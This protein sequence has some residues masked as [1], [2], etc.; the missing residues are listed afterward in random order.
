MKIKTIL[1][2]LL[3]T[4]LAG[5][6]QGYF[7][8]G[9]EYATYTMGSMKSFQ[10]YMITSSGVTLKPVVN[11]P[12]FFGFG[13]TGG[14]Q[15]G[16]IGFGASLGYNTTAGRSDYED[17]SGKA[18]IDQLL[19]AYSFH[20]FL[21]G[22]VNQS[23]TWPLFFVMDIS[24]I[25]TRLQINSDVEVGYQSQSSSSDFYS[26]NLGF[27]PSFILQ[28]D[29]KN[30]FFLMFKAGYEFQIEGKLHEKG[31]SNAYLVGSDGEVTANWS[32][33][34]LGVSVGIYFRKKNESA[35]QTMTK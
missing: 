22:Q 2:L 34:R 33:V 21:K 20:S 35:N 32:G 31:D 11:F 26:T 6:S 8:V 28:R 23:N 3:L 5:R 16:R 12:A 10:S 13:A 27:Q 15:F 19:R 4:P 18:R 9:T 30:N 25:Q 1:L 29:L 14:A 17:Y 24:Y 7:A